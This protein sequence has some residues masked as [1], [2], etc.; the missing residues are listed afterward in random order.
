MGAF[1]IVETIQRCPACEREASF[2]VQ[3]KFGELWQYH[4]EIGDLIQW[5]ERHRRQNEGRPDLGRV[6]VDGAAES[7]AH[8]IAEFGNQS[9]SEVNGRLG[10][11]NEIF[12]TQLKQL[13][14][15]LEGGATGLLPL[16]ER[17]NATLEKAI[18][19]EAALEQ[20][21]TRFNE[22]LGHNASGFVDEL[23]QNLR[24]VVLKHN[25]Q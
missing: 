12:E 14:N 10:H 22:V 16:L 6:A 21:T 15:V 13:E 18:G 1:P 19:L 9:A 24:H 8:K 20:S 23:Q 2:L 4:Y 17:H 3:F 5:G 11:L 25:I 7:A